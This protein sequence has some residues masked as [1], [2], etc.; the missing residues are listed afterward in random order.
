LNLGTLADVSDIFNK[1][2]INGRSW[3]TEALAISSK[4]VEE[5]AASRV[6]RLALVTQDTTTR[7]KHDEEVEVLALKAIVEVQC[8]I[9][10]G[11]ENRIEIV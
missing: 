6:I 5:G 11:A 9:D 7:A 3:K 8:T 4:S 1:A 2:E 10:L